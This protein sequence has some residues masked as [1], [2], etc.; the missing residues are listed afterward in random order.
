MTSTDFPFSLLLQT[1][2]EDDEGRA[3]E[4]HSRS[5]QEDLRFVSDNCR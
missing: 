2:P 5:Q 4:V 1:I 3:E